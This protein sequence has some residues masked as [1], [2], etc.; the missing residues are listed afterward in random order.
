MRLDLTSPFSRILL[1]MRYFGSKSSTLA[2]LD[3]LI[4]ERVPEGSFC[5]CFGGIGTVGSYFK[6]LG[7]TVYTGDVLTFAHYFQ[8]ARVQIDELPPFRNLGS[9]LGVT[10]PEGVRGFLNQTRPRQGWFVREY[11]D[12]R[13][14]FSRKNAM[15]IQACRATIQQWDRQGW[16]SSEERAL[17][18][19]SLIKAADRVAN[20]AGTYYAYLKSWHRK[21]LQDFH[22]EWIQS[23]PG[24]EACRSVLA[25]AVELAASR[26]FDVLYLDPPYNARSYGA[27]YHLPETLATGGTPPVRGSSGMPVRSFEPSEYNRRRFASRALE[28]LL[29]TA[30]FRL[31]AFHYADDGLIPPETIR[32]LLRRYGT[33]EEFILPSKGYTTQKASRIKNHRI[34]LVTDA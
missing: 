13:Q 7:Y 10:G 28:C 6:R 27:Y 3:R 19:A 2:D 30:R 29:T 12:Q 23:T 17:L 21:A 24:N 14:F 11:S 5:D 4:C 20:T 8:I 25:P 15:R 26:H 1:R 18:L 32:D 16:L 9:K 31:L 33:V 34:Y 22:F